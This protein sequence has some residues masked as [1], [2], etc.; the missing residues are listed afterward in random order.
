MFR[1]EPEFVD[2]NRYR[3]DKTEYGHHHEAECWIPHCPWHGFLP[4]MEPIGRNLPGKL[5]FDAFPA[6]TVDVAVPEGAGRGVRGR[7]CRTA[8]R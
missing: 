7:P 8:R 5:A 1:V 2:M 3:G 4:V 6:V